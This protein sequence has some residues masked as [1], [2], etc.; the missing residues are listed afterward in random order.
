MRPTLCLLG[1]MLAGCAPSSDEGTS[2]EDIYGGIRDDEVASSPSPV[3]ALRIANTEICSGVL[4]GP[5][6][7][8]TARHCVSKSET[9]TV[10]CDEEGHSLAGQLTGDLPP[11]DIAVYVG[12]T[13]AF[14]QKPVATAKA[15]FT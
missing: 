3:V 10:V 1:A 12:T 15:I 2:S 9:D 6:V 8:L 5:N 11:A 13:P 4:I 7:V 14:A